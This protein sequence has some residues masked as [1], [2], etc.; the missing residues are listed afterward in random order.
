MRSFHDDMFLMNVHD[1][2][3]LGQADELP[4]SLLSVQHRAST[5]I[6]ICRFASRISAACIAIERSG[7]LSG[8]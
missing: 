5:P 2:E 7:V 4:G 1:K 3:E 8:L 6:A